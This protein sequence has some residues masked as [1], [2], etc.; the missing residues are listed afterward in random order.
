MAVPSVDVFQTPLGVVPLD[1]DALSGLLAHDGVS[2]WDAPHAADH[3]LE[4]QLPFLQTVL[5][6]FSLVPIAVGPCQPAVVAAVLERL[7][8]GPETLIVVSTDLSHFHPYSHAQTLDAATAAAI[9]RGESTL[10]GEQACGCHALNGLLLCA[11]RLGLP[12]Q[13]LDLR[14]SGD[15]AGGHDRVVGYGSFVVSRD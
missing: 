2:E 15:T 8:G 13:Q 3:A 7:W 6:A 11:R 5:G 10:N 1:R 14:N 9:V 4:V 12:V